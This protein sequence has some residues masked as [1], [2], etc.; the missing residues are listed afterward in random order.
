MEIKEVKIKLA[1]NKLTCFVF[2]PRQLLEFTFGRNTRVSN[3]TPSTACP[4]LLGHT[5]RN[6][7]DVDLM[8][9]S[10][11]SPE[12]KIRMNL[13]WLPHPRKMHMASL[14]HA[15]PTRCA[16]QSEGGTTCKR[17]I[18]CIPKFGPKRRRSQA[19]RNSQNQ[20][21]LKDCTEAERR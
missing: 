8:G 20:P 13:V 19:F 6:Y 10:T 2:L 1:C 5:E 12:F 18:R 3:R 7:R 4:K 16:T 11:A 9:L 17:D 15:Q 21:H 14:A